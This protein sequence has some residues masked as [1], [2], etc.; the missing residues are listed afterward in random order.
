MSEIL[1]AFLV[2][3][4]EGHYPVG[5]AAIVYAHDREQAKRLLRDELRKQ[6]LGRDNPDEWTLEPLTPGPTDPH[7]RVVLNGDY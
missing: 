1:T 6:Y 5:T 4:F 2:T 7:A 3:H